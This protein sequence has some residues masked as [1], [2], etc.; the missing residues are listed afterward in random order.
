[1][2]GY[3]ATDEAMMVGEEDGLLDLERS[4]WMDLRDLQATI[5]MIV[6]CF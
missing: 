4:I 2:K 1:M 3:E 5:F 6:L